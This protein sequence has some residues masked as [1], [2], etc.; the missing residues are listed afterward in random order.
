MGQDRDAGSAVVTGVAGIGVLLAI[1]VGGLNLVIDEYAKGAVRTAVDEAAQA[2]AAAGGSVVGCELKAA[3]V[4]TDLLPG[5][6]GREVTVDCSRRGDEMV[7][8]AA[9]QLPSLVPPVPSVHLS[10][11]GFSL[12]EEVPAQ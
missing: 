9:G 5:P 10:L 11:S 4:R 8:S 12:I 1:F 2:G 3:Q 7:A 6:F